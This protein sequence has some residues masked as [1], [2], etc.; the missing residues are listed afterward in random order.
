MRRLIEL[1]ALFTLLA[2]S[3]TAFADPIV[4]F[5]AQA[6][7]AE[8]T[9]GASTAWFG[10]VAESGAYTPR[11]SEYARILQ[12]EN[13]DGIVRLELEVPRP[14]AVWLVV[15]MS[16]GQRT[17]AAPAGVVLNRTVLPSASLLGGGTNAVA[18]VLVENETLAVCWVVR[19]SVGAWRMMME[20]GSNLDVDGAS[21][22]SVTSVLGGLDA[23]DQSPAAPAGLASG[24]I[25]VIV[26]LEQLAVTD[27]RV[28]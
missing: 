20:D 19:P 4:I 2:L 10:L 16:T 14:V 12:D 9:P 24:D 6:V 26:S 17:I 13:N 11:T 1:L 23:V 7:V 25:V 27:L 28:D 15:D 18:G 5:E 3:V 8:V 22:G 21:D